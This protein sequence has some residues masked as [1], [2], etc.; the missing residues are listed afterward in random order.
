MLA[1][2]NVWR[3][4][5]THLRTLRRY[6]SGRP[7]VS[8]WFTFLVLPVILSIAL[9]ACLDIRSSDAINSLITVL[10]ILAGFSFN[11]LAII[12]GY[13]G[14]IKRAI[15]PKDKA[16]KQYIREI[17]GNIS[18][19]VL[20][21]LLC[22]LLLLLL[23]T[24]LKVTLPSFTLGQVDVSGIELVELITFFLLSFYALTLLMII[25]RLSILFEHDEQA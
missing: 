3:I 8:D 23:K 7:A 4:V 15:G 21:A 14:K 20:N 18:F 24:E 9:S 16:K 17:H 11:L 13:Q 2:V 6:D 10:S 1:K 22:I 19:S 12:F 25:K 5:K